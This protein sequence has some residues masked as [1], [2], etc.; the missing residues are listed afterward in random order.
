MINSDVLEDV[1]LLNG[2][3][4]QRFGGH[5]GAELDFRLREGSRERRVVR[6]DVSGTGASAI[7]EG[8]FG[9]ERKG[10]WLLAGRQS[11]LDLIVHHLTSRSVSFGFS[12]AQAKLVYG[13]SWLVSAWAR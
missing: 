10:S 12:D 13:A 6:L 2:G 5:T 7:V 3:Y 1:A 4:A 11:Y 8:P 9:R